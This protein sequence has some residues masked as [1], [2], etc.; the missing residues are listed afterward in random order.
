MP[1]WDKSLHHT[2]Q[3][4]PL[5]SLSRTMITEPLGLYS[6]LSRTMITTHLGPYST[7]S[8]TMITEPSGPYSFP[9]PLLRYMQT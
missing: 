5:G 9:Y 7:L 8:S 1:I 3:F 4:A 6:S 2:D